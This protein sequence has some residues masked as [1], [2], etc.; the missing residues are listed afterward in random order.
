MKKYIT[1]TLILAG[2]LLLGW[3][4]FGNATQVQT[5]TDAVH[6]NHDEATT[7][8]DTDHMWTCSMHPHIMLP[9]SGDCPICGMDLIPNIIDVE[10]LSTDQFKLTKNAMALAN[11]ETS[12]VGI[13]TTDSNHIKLS[14]KIMINEDKTATQPAHFDGRIENLYVNS[15]GEHVKMGQ[16]IAQIYSP[17]LIA[18]QQE[19]ITAYSIR[20][21]QPQLYKAVRNKFK[22]LKIRDTQL[23]K[24]ETSRQVETKFTIYS[25]VSGI[26]SDIIVNEGA[27]ITDGHPIFKVA[28]LSTVWANFDVYEHQINQFKKGQEITITAAAYPNTEF[29]A[30]IAFI[31]PVLNT[32]TRTITVRAILD[33]KEEKFKP[34][35]F[36]EASIEGITPTSTPTLS[37]PATAV[38]WTGKRSV[39]YIK[40]SPDEPVFKMQEITLGTN[41]GGTYQVLE[42][43]NNGD[44]IVTNGTFT[45]DAAAQLQGKKS[46]MN[47]KK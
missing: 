42:G 24:I 21:T 33:N 30:S 37:I 22:N 23:S 6:M 31:D 41:L 18:A 44:E 35:M 3:L 39:V 36:V 5:S 14:G 29:K 20:E 38:L 15:V 40:T 16:A 26:V 1:Y 47:Q 46:M 43:L 19:L 13:P 4:I 9:E 10:D 11:I 8:M 34:G 12:M 28:N 17:E 27:H 25:H 32:K 7:D 45:V 2:G